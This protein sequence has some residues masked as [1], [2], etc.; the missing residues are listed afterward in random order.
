MSE[1]FSIDISNIFKERKYNVPVLQRNYEWE[2]ENIEQLWNDLFVDEIWTHGINTVEPHFMGT[3]VTCPHQSRGSSDKTPSTTT[4]NLDILDG[5]QRL[6]TLTIFLVEA[7]RVMLREKGNF[8]H[9]GTVKNTIFVNTRKEDKKELRLNL[10]PSLDLDIYHYYTSKIHLEDV[11]DI[12]ISI[13]KHNLQS[14][15]PRIRIGRNKLLNCITKSKEL[16][17]KTIGEALKHNLTIRTIM[18]DICYRLLSKTTFLQ[19]NT[20]SASSAY[21]IFES[22][23]NRGVDLSQADL[24]KNKLCSLLAEGELDTFSESWNL[25]KNDVSAEPNGIV[26]YLR[27]YIITKYGHVTKN[28]LLD[29]YVN[30]IG[31]DIEPND[32]KIIKKNLDELI[33]GLCQHASKFAQLTSP[34]EVAGP[35]NCKDW[36]E[37]ISFLNKLQAKT[38]R[39][40][41]LSA[42]MNNFKDLSKLVDIITVMQLRAAI[43]NENPNKIEKAHCIVAKLIGDKK[44][45]IDFSE[46]EKVY[47]VLIPSNED[48]F[49]KFMTVKATSIPVWRHILERYHERKSGT[50]MNISDTKKVHVEHIL[51]IKANQE[52]QLESE[53]SKDELE[54]YVH[55]PGNL[56]LLDHKLN[57]KAQNDKFSR[58]K[59][60]FYVKSKIP[61][62]DIF[63]DKAKWT[64]TDITERTFILFEIVTEIW[65]HPIEGIVT[66]EKLSEYKSISL[67]DE[68]GDS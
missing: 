5:Q 57:I 31:I 41:L 59:T 34:E 33:K 62:N 37:K 15:Y 42:L 61:M 65:K 52:S 11:A 56:T 8:D 16:L 14:K 54:L 63:R 1:T 22:L 6:T 40:A 12:D 26:N 25:I 13:L 58:K 36:E 28:D 30:L 23:N 55:K 43:T 21:R 32:K 66:A 29:K 4:K 47:T 24:I 60:E 49:K 17:N 51:A 48:F 18:D 39:H 45:D 19:I 68:N 3:V 2:S 50:E 35:D 67:K 7:Y 27:S 9:I 10:Q 64:K 38:C 53:I 46:I 44:G 20:S